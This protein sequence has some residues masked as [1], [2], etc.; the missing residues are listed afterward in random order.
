MHHLGI[1]MMI[2]P[3]LPALELANKCL[4]H[5]SETDFKAASQDL[6]TLTN[7]FEKYENNEIEFIDESNFAIGIIARYLHRITANMENCKNEFGD[8]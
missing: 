4:E 3:I 8:I 1:A 2:I 7:Y 6:I 5:I